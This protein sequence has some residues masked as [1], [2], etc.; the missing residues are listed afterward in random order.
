[1]RLVPLVI[2]AAIVAASG[3]VGAV[4]SVYVA[5]WLFTINAP[6]SDEL[7]RTGWGF[8]LY[9]ALLAGGLVGVLTSVVAMSRNPHYCTWCGGVTAVVLLAMMRPRSRDCFWDG[10]DLF[11]LPLVMALSLLACGII[12]LK[13]GA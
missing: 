5:M 1:M 11:A 8:N 12:L 7:V 10:V 6:R 13:T 4:A 3:V 9:A 2:G